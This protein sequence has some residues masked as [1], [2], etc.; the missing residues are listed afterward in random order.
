M[1]RV[2]TLHRQTCAFYISGRQT[3]LGAMGCDDGEGNLER[4]ITHS[5]CA[6]VQSR[7]IRCRRE[8]KSVLFQPSKMGW[9]KTPQNH[10][11]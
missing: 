1:F 2:A 11:F 3:S 6:E 4:Y 8:R 7:G 10:A 5:P 9:A